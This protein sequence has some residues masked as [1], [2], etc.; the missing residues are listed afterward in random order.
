MIKTEIKYSYSQNEG[1][2]LREAQR[3]ISE[4]IKLFGINKDDIIE[5]RTETWCNAYEFTSTYH[6]KITLSWWKST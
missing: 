5:Y 1:E 4:T 2:C 3:A 6:C